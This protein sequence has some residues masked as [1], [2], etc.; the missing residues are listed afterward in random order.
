MLITF[1]IHMKLELTHRKKKLIKRAKRGLDKRFKKKQKKCTKMNNNNTSIVKL[2]SYS[3]DSTAIDLV[4]NL[5]NRMHHL[6]ISIHKFEY[7]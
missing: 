5:S 1:S 2:K 3:P 7:D 4:N 6:H